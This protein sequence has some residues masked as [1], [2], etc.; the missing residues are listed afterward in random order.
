MNILSEK[1]LNVIKNIAYR[2]IL[3]CMNKDHIKH[4]GTYLEKFKCKWFDNK[5]EV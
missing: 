1:W 4:L 5:I 2:D 3:T